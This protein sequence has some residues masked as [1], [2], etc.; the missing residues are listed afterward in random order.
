MSIETPF[1]STLHITASSVERFMVGATL[2]LLFG[3]ISKK[4]LVVCCIALSAETCSDTVVQQ[5]IWML[6]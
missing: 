2:V 5:S 6:R 1:Q 3:A 4:S